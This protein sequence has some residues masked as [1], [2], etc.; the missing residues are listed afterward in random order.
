MTLGSVKCNCFYQRKLFLKL[1]SS[2]TLVEELVL[3]FTAA[4]KQLAAQ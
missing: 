4:L 1:G 3:S 2:S